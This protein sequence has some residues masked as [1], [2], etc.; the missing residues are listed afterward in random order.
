[1]EGASILIVEDEAISALYLKNLLTRLKYQVLDI[2]ASGENAVIRA[3]DKKPDLVLMDIR[4][5][6]EMDGI[7]AADII[8]SNYDVPV[9]FL[10]A[11][12]DEDSMRRA[13]ATDPAG[14]VPKPTSERELCGTIEMALKNDILKKQLRASEARFRRIFNT[15][16]VSI[17]EIDFSRVKKALDNLRQGG[18]NILESY[19]ETNSNYIN[20]LLSLVDILDANDWSLQLFNAPDQK[21]FTSALIKFIGTEGLIIFRKLLMAIW[22]EDPYYDGEGY[23]RT[24]NGERKYVTINVAFLT[25]GIDLSRVLMI[26]TD[27]TQGKIAEMALRESEEK[28]RRIINTAQEG[29]W[30][31]NEDGKTTYLN[32]RI[33]DMF[34]YTLEEMIGESVKDFLFPE[35]HAYLEERV[36]VRSTGIAERYEMRFRRKDGNELWVII[37]ATP[38]MSDQ[39][40]YLGS[41]AMLTDI[42]ER[43]RAEQALSESEERYRLLIEGA[44]EIIGVVQGNHFAYINRQAEQ[45]TGYSHQELITL[46]IK[47]FVHPDDYEMIVTIH[48]RKMNGE[49]AISPYQVRVV[50]KSGETKWLDVKSA[51]ISWMG[52]SALLNFYTDITERRKAEEQLRFQAMVL[53]QIQDRVT[54]TDLNGRITYVNDA[55]SQQL[56][57]SRQ[58]LLGQSV[59]FY[60]EDSTR[61]ATQQEI[62]EKTFTQGEWCGEVVNF[63]ADGKDMILDCR[64]RLMYDEQGE[65]IAMC[66]ISTDITQRKQ[67]EKALAES[68]A[69]YRQIVE[70]TQEGVWIL[71]KNFNLVFANHRIINMLGY[72]YAELMEKSTNELIFPEDLADHK[73]QLAARAK[74]NSSQYERRFRCKDGSSIWMNE[75]ASPIINDNG[76]F[77]GVVSLFTD[78]SVRKRAEK[79]LEQH[80]TVAQMLDALSQELLKLNLDFKVTLQNAARSIFQSSGDLCIIRLVSDDGLYLQPVAIQHPFLKKQ[81]E[82]NK[83]INRSRIR[84]DEG[85]FGSIVKTGQSVIMSRESTAELVGLIPNQYTTLLKK[86][87]IVSGLSI[88]LRVQ[89]SIIG[90]L[91]L[92]RSEGQEPFNE[93]DRNIFQE[94][95]DRIGL[96]IEN[97]RMYS[98]AQKEIEERRKIEAAVRLSEAKYRDLFELSPDSNIL[99]NTEGIIL[100]C[101]L[102]TSKISG[103]SKEEM[104]GKAFFEIVSVKPEILQRYLIFIKNGNPGDQRLPLETEIT[105]QDGQKLDIEIFPKMIKKEGV[106]TGVQVISR[107]ITDRK[108]NEQKIKDSLAEKETLLSELNHRV[109]NNLASIISIMD[110]Q[111]SYL[112]DIQMVDLV[113]ELQE[114]VRLMALIH[115]QLYRS[116]NLNQVD[117]AKY[118]EDLTTNLARALM[119]GRDISLNIHADPA[120]MS[121]AIAIPCGQIVTELVTNALKYA[122]PE[123]KCDLWKDTARLIEINFKVVGDR[124]ILQVADNGV[125]L[126]PGLNFANAE[127][128]GMQ[129]VTL[130][131]NQLNGTIELNGHPGVTATVIFPNI[132]KNNR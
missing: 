119:K 88:P 77:Q 66:G 53:D 81:A 14:Y 107:D 126:H 127:T 47:T 114:R 95:A 38:I 101:N 93:N 83:I 92:G 123:E 7:Q 13:M 96:T 91:V 25:G 44:A 106:I 61:G 85:I 48:R 36:K 11:H 63:D 55:E 57:Y 129:L 74:G 94:V 28:Y 2:V 109:K 19:L 73:A 45:A 50:T 18:I 79:V 64:T 68:E 31:L 118:L 35:Q 122:F 33:R 56:K 90:D 124:F 16:S 30:I 39:G 121:V 17:S 59:E 12:L 67:I 58:Q 98:N 104:V 115:E 100:D 75:T 34:G 120:Q 51:L 60:G 43:K 26:I 132:S 80:Q 40:K 108:L 41:F 10:T 24:R 1:M 29:V 21:E 97:A 70:T 27:I 72:S 110:L 49:S 3:G 125:G 87:N 71:D 52:A 113:T 20:E 103:L 111:K 54:V 22:K 128:L 15:A 105:L 99:L 69:R 117:F 84:V 8:H 86:F 6:G 82:I 32:N 131:T 42:T 65:P 130:L 5:A 112:S 37:S 116:K 23:I 76:E 89:G 46:P 102:S 4:L 9:V 78:I 62:I